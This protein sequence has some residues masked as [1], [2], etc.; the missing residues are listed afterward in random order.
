MDNT[1]RSSTE[2]VLVLAE[3]WRFREL[4]R[5]LV[6]RNLRIKYQRSVLGFFWTL[7]NPLLTVAVLISIFHYIVP[8]PVE[9]YWAFLVSGY[10]VWNFVLQMLNAST[11]VILEHAPLYRNVAFPAEVLVFSA[12]MSRLME[13]AV[14]MGLAILLLAVF[15]HEGIPLSFAL[16]PLLVVLQML[17]TVGLA[18]MVA[19]LSVFYRDVEVVVPVILLM[20]FWLSPV[21]YPASMVPDAIK[22]FYF[23]NPFA[24]LLTLYHTVFY[25]GRMPSLAFLGAM[26]GAALVIG[27]VGYGIFNRKKR[28]FAEIV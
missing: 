2:R 20:L 24:G 14:E 9:H 26:S 17:I 22:S 21:F 11:T 28:F 18:M 4:L 15:L 13:F 8:L 1:P 19:T 27:L 23:L 6:L 5:S 12:A 7:L 10:F 25:E 16:F 3:V